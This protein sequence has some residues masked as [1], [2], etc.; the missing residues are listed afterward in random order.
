MADFVL[1]I[2][3]GTTACKATLLSL[4]GNHWTVESKSYPTIYLKESWVEQD[5]EIWWRTIGETVKQIRQM[6]GC[7]SEEIRSIGLTG[8]MHGLIL[9]DKDGEL[10]RPAMLWSDHRSS[11]QCKWLIHHVPEIETITCNHVLPA[12]TLPKLIWIRDHENAIYKKIHRILLPKDY[13]RLRLTG[14]FFTEP[15]DASGTSMY[16]VRSLGWSHQILSTLDIPLDWLPKCVPSTA[17]TDRLTESAANHFDLTPGI[18]V[19]GGGADQAAQAIAMGV[20]HPRILGLTIGTSGVI[21]VTRKKPVQGS[22]CHA[23]DQRWLQLDSIHSAGLSLDWYRDSFHPKLSYKALESMAQR[24]PVGSRN[25]LFMPFLLGERQSAQSSVPASFLGIH[26]QH[27]PSHFVRAIYEGVA[28]EFMRMVQNWLGS[29]VKVDEVRFSGGGSKSNLWQVI[30]A[31]LLDLPVKRIDQSASF[32][33]CIL[34]GVGAGWWDSVEGG[35]EANLKSSQV[36]ESTPSLRD[37][38]QEYYDRYKK[39]YEI[40]SKRT[41]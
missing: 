5:P 21:V 39:F 26:P 37:L 31:S 20:T 38:Y 6:A 14:G 13:L 19:V 8:Q 35:I 1:G 24:V 41:E 22:F 34:A 40:L 2:D 10:L 25:L 17:V 12:F 29:G 33:A 3:L 32:G 16:D 11:K 9:L 18:P 23:L 15:S 28:F 30:I 4:N 27:D 7:K 36:E